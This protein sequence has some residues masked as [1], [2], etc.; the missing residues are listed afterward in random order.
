[1]FFNIIDSDCSSGCSTAPLINPR[2]KRN[3][4][5]VPV[6]SKADIDIA[7][8][9][10]R[11]AFGSWKLL[12]LEKRQHY[13][14]EL[15]DKL[16]TERNEIHYALANET[17]KSDL[18]AQMEIDDSLDFIKFN[19][20]Q[21]LDDEV[22]FEDEK[23]KI[24]STHAPIG[25][26]GAICPWNFPLVLAVA[27]IAAA[28]V[29]GNCIIVKPSPFTPCATLKFAEL[30]IPILPPGVLQALNGNNDI[31][32]IM[33]LH[34]GID[35]ISFTGST[36]TGKKVAENAAR[37]LKRVTLEL[38]GN[39]ASI[40]CP[41]VDVQAVATKLA[42]GVFFHSGQMCVATKRVYVHQIIFAEFRDAFVQAVRAIEVKVAGHQ[43]SLFSPLQNKMQ[44]DIVKELIKD[45]RGNGYNIICGG[46]PEEG[47]PGFF[48]TPTVVDRPPDDSQ[49][50][51]KEQFGPI[52]PLMEWSAEDEV[53]AR[54]NDTDA[55]L[56][57]CVWASDIATAE[58]IARKLEVG[59]V[60][61]NNFEV[62]SPYG[63][64]SGWKQSGV[65]GEWG[66]QGL[67][68]YCH[69]QTIQFY[70]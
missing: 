53:V 5:D 13:L 21:P 18:L 4:W 36:A 35:K 39:D 32:Q 12:T 65:G 64:F 47:L 61:I 17:G 38:G 58:R 25:V 23:L 16:E 10:A 28:L 11:R 51:Q 40:V 44:Y 45:S 60:W 20:S 68:S 34:P 46:E 14:L 1:M 63:Y 2:T 66:R 57:S 27:K 9:A 55:G 59:T 6:A 8:Q 56:G 37:T 67:R 49:I 19:A 30:A 70:N 31:G 50:V 41:D 43:P 33:T 24:I 42:L 3:L 15:A 69:T 7:V 22:E 52:I 29:T 62:P 26:V 48:I 54:V